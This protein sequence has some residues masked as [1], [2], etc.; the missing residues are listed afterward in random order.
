MSSEQHL[1]LRVA[2]AGKDREEAF[3]LPAGW[4]ARVYP[5]AG[6]PAL[7]PEQVRGAF[8]RTLGVD[9]IA[10]AARGAASAVILVDDFRRP[11]PAEAL[12]S[13]VLDELA[14]AGIARERVTIIT[15]NGVHRALRG[16]EARRLGSALEGIGEWVLHDGYSPDVRFMGLTSAGTP[17][18]VN[19][20]AARAD[21][22]VAISTVYPHPLTTWGGGAKLVLPGIS[23][24]SSVHHHHGRIKG[25]PRAGSPGRC[26]SRRDI[27]EA[28]RLF[29]LDVAVCSV[30]NE[31]KELCGLFVGEPTKA[32][33][34]AIAFARRVYHTELNGASP[35]LAIANGYPM[36]ADPTQISKS[37]WP[38]QHFGVPTVLIFDFAAPSPYHGLYHGRLHEFRKRQKQRRC[39][40]DPTKLM[41]AK[42]ILY[43]PQYGKGFVPTSDGWYY[44]SHWPRLM[45]GLQQRLPCA[46]VAVFPAASLQIPAP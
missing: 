29:G 39:T 1:R 31:Q 19:E 24:V 25:G 20:A 28:A 8:A 45:E 12:C 16:K 9:R 18:L 38:A 37:Q 41:T 13:G 22:S 46:S 11:T 10:R 14:R 30:M 7:S 2:S 42:L 36:D 5:P 26:P 33:R 23:H 40:Q 15:G 17:V 3:P 32:H 4:R 35:D 44:A 27:E 6:A 34:R 43:S 21:F